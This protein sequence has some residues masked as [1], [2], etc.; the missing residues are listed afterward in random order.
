MSAISRICRV[1]FSLGLISSLSGFSISCNSAADKYVTFNPLPVEKGADPSKDMP[2]VP[3]DAQYTIYCK[4]FA[5]MDHVQE[6]REAQ[7]Q[8][9][10]ATKD[11]QKW[12]VVHSDDHST[13]YYG[14][15]RCID[16]RDKKDGA[17]GQRAIDDQNKIRSIVTSSGFRLF[18]E[19][20]LVGIDTPDPQANPAWDLTRTAG[21]WTI[22][23][24]TFTTADRKIKA[25]EAVKEAR[26][27]GIEAYYYHGE[28]ASSVCIGAWP[29]SSATEITTD[30]QNNNPDVPVVV[31]S[32]PLA[33]NVVDQYQ[34]NGI[35][36]IS[37]HVEITDL[38]L[39]AALHKYPLHA[40]DGSTKY[41]RVDPVTNEGI[42]PIEKSFVCKIP[43]KEQT[44]QMARNA[45]AGDFDPLAKIPAGN[46]KGD[47]PGVGQLRS[48]GQ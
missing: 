46:G 43:H 34:K 26:A 22:E 35:N 9:F 44:Y 3:K 19:S 5:G 7:H 16:P 13:L 20:L 18:P 27:S 48:L 14:F 10:E 23:I 6:S 30:I 36:P 12:Y 31:T 40:T 25:V 38:T 15:Y 45:G 42:N 29:A 8:L 32:D 21:T 4:V 11:L 41:E 24:G 37:S 39:T 17:E 2:D 47:E 28:T 33:K 1:V